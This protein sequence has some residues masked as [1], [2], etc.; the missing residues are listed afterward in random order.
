MQALFWPL[1][2]VLGI[3]GLIGAGWLLHRFCIRLEEAGYL[4][5]R[6][7]SKGSPAAGILGELDKLVR[8][9]IEHT[10]ELQETTH[11]EEDGI[12]GN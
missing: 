8:P 10:I 1:I 4:Y 11:V 7:E 5:Y 3:A 12:D 6:E 9:N 2:I